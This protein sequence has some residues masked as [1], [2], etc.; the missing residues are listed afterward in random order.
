MYAHESSYVAKRATFGTK[1]LW[2]TQYDPDELHAAGDFPNQ[3]PGGDGLPAYIAKDRPLENQ[4]VVLWHTVG[5]THIARPEDWPVMPVEYAGFTLKPIGFF[6]RNPALDVPPSH[7]DHCATDDQG[8]H[9]AH[10]NGHD[11]HHH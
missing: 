4:D 10:H 9:A 5:V 2:V 3:H 11:G 6:E 7:G 1:T 8:D